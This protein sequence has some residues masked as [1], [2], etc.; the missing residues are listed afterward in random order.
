MSRNFA[1]TNWLIASIALSCSEPAP[2]S[3]HQAQAQVRVV[4]VRL[5][6]VPAPDAIVMLGGDERR[7]P[8]DAHGTA[9]VPSA[10]LGPDAVVMA[11]HEQARTRAV[12]LAKAGA[13]MLALDLQTL[14][15]TDNAR[16]VFGDPGEPER[17]GSTEQCGHC[18]VSINA[19]WFESPHRGAAKNPVVV[20]LYAG[21][22][23]ALSTQAACAERGGTW[24]A[25]PSPGSGEL[26]ERCHVGDG[27]LPALNPCGGEA[28]CVPESFGGCAD[29]HA[30]GI[31]GR[32]GGRDLLEA[33]GFAY[34]YGVHCDVC[35]KVEAIHE[36]DPP[37][38]AG[39]LGLRRPSEPSP[40][41]GLGDWKPVTFGPRPDVP[42]PLMGGVE[43][44][45]FH[46]GRLCAG[47]H[48]LDQPALVPGTALDTARWP[49]GALPIHSTYE[50][51]KSGPSAGSPC[52]SCHMPP[53][54]GVGNSADLFNM[55]GGPEG[56]AA[57]W[58]R[59]PGSVRRHSWLGPRA[60][61]SG[62][63]RL[64]A[65][66]FV[67]KTLAPGEVVAEVTV[68]NAGAGHALPTGEPMRS[69]LLVV[70]A[71]CGDSRLDAVGGD[72]I[73][74]FGGYYARKATGQDWTDWPGA[75]KGQRVTVIS[76][77]GKHRDYEGF[78]PFGDGR[79]TKEQKGMPEDVAAGSRLITSVQGSKVTFDA[80]LP[81][82]DVAYRV[83]A[84]SS[85]KD[86]SL[87]LARAGAAGFAFA[88][89]LVGTDG[90]RMV[91]HFL[92]VDLASDNR[93]LPG[94]AVTT[95]HR[96]KS[97]CAEPTVEA[98]L[99]YRALPFELARERGFPL[100]E[101]VLAEAKR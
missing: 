20:D 53:N 44:T 48:Q 68:E 16:Y 49:G 70:S 33:R 46:D 57:G 101:L 60:P 6:G 58:E 35:H 97:T 64:A 94:R 71:R 2:P 78:G 26:G 86:G 59:A 1:L 10:S 39:R 24:R 54:P 38:V 18:H 74:D 73:P 62:F 66:L 55:F 83:D 22:S 51:W 56:I 96:F 50:E 5:D 40:S 12:E 91:P 84:P 23:S 77:T 13:G 69:V 92:A 98:A 90:R 82:G 37:G 80:P 32:L 100:T 76:R 34:D 27:V 14:D 52:P 45:H 65:A 61:A 30:P 19:D 15:P 43:R 8:T 89:V 95:K 11:A 93:I 75:K 25:S 21:T 29:C 67:E 9:R 7:W 31:D 79:F 41:P 42:N 88:R 87:S 99:V 4:Q 36:A 28:R 81:S 63:A 47:C 17:R 72:A 3:A 85:P